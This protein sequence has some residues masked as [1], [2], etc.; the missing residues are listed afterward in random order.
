MKKSIKVLSIILCC[1]L[2]TNA[3]GCSNKST[4]ENTERTSSHLS[5]QTR[6]SKPEAPVSEDV[7]ETTET[8]LEDSEGLDFVSLG[9][10]TAIVNGLGDCTFMN[11]KIPSVTPDG[12]KVTE[13]APCAFSKNPYLLSV[14]IPEG[15]TVIGDEAFKDCTSLTHVD[16]P[17]SV[18]EIGKFA[19]S[20]CTSLTECDLPDYL[21]VI[22]C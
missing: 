14:V 18:Y 13:I 15:V 2:I 6:D 19:F 16:I 20:N 7:S 22:T 8:E 21:S 4:G 9:D 17:D 1:F 5:E 3:I 10:G 12:D 11:V